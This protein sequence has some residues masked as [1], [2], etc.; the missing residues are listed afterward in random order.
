L[1]RY[2]IKIDEFPDPINA[3]I[4]ST[5]KVVSLFER[6]KKNRNI[7]AIFQLL[8]TFTLHQKKKA[9]TAIALSAFLQEFINQ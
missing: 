3:A 5:T 1:S 6:N 8:F 2:F 4:F 9:P 7:F